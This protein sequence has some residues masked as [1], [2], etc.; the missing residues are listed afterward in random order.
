MLKFDMLFSSFSQVLLSRTLYASVLPPW[1]WTYWIGSNKVIYLIMDAHFSLLN[2]WVFYSHPF[3]FLSKISIQ[4]EYGKNSVCV[5]VL[6]FSLLYFPTIVKYWTGKI[7]LLFSPLAFS[8][9]KQALNAKLHVVLWYC[10]AI[11]YCVALFIIVSN[12]ISEVTSLFSLSLFHRVLK[13]V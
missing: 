13:E 6:N 11:F 5:Q 7:L 4:K 9:I 8:V 10:G 12:Y 3:S 2:M 1:R